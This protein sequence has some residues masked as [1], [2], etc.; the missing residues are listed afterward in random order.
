MANAIIAHSNKPCIKCGSTDR[1]INKNCRPCQLLSA[2]RWKTKHRESILNS[3]EPIF[4]TYAHIRKDTGQV[5]YIGKGSFDRAYHNKN[6]N[7]HWHKIVDKHGF[8]VQI[9]NRWHDEKDSLA[10]EVK[11]IAEYKAKGVR[12]CNYTIGGDGISGHRHSAE[13]RAKLSAMQIGKVISDAQRK[14]LS[15]A[16]KGRIQPEDVRLKISLKNSGRKR[17]PEQI[18]ANSERNKGKKLSIEHRLAISAGNI[19]RKHSQE[20]KEKIG[21]K[22]IGQTISVE[23]RLAIS[24]ANKGRKF[25]AEVI[26]KRVLTM[27]GKPCKEETKRKISEAHKGKTIPLEVRQKIIAKLTGLKQSEETK[28]KRRE[29]LK[30]TWDLKKLNK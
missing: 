2:R 14:K 8:E 6:R 19:G 17:T 13:T 12:L 4:Y 15:E 28:A 27:T 22:K 10:D 5:F 16:G 26:A 25:S 18:K 7:N 11:L 29:S 1:D 20:T 3:G 23:H 30:K 9:L 24:Q 21:A